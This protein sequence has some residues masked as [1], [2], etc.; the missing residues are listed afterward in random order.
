MERWLIAFLTREDTPL[1][2]WPTKTP[3]SEQPTKRERQAKRKADEASYT[4]AHPTEEAR[5]LMGLCIVP[6]K[7]CSDT[8][9]VKDPRPP[10][11]KGGGKHPRSGYS[12]RNRQSR[13]M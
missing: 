9:P 13:G 7:G 8:P 6:R 3:R 11:P 1:D 5:A 2:Q 4:K 10:N 12:R